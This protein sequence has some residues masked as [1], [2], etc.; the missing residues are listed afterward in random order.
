MLYNNY[1]LN[2][3]MRLIDKSLWNISS[4]A[5]KYVWCISY[6]KQRN[7]GINLKYHKQHMGL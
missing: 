7:V 4:L 3:F 1:I 2:T 5:D 6:L